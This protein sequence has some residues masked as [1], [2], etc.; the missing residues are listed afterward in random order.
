MSKLDCLKRLVKNITGQESNAKSVCG[1]LDELADFYEPKKVATPTAT[2]AAGEVASGTT[3]A[4]STTTE[5]AD[6]YYT[7]NGDTPTAESTKYTA[8]IEITEAVTIKAIGIKSGMT[9][10]DVMTAAYTVS[11]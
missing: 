11:E 9:N 6:I 10:S 1:A 3:V 5:G 4:L 7:T 2:P 8:A